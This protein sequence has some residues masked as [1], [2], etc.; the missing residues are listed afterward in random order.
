MNEHALRRSAL[1]NRRL[2]KVPV[3]KIGSPARE[4]I[5]RASRCDAAEYPPEGSLHVGIRRFPPPVVGVR[6][7]I[8]RMRRFGGNANSN[9]HGNSCALN[10]TYAKN[11]DYETTQRTGDCSQAG[12]FAYRDVAMSC[13]G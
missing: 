9:C 4:A 13:N 7:E 5:G 2:K 6:F 1:L 10:N 11:L 12:M 3:E 8:D